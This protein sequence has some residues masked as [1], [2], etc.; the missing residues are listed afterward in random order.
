MGNVIKISSYRNSNSVNNDKSQTREER[1][2]GRPSVLDSSFAG[3]AEK[4]TQNLRF[5][6]DVRFANNHLAAILDARI[7]RRRLKRRVRDEIS[8]TVRN[9]FP[10]SMW[11]EAG[12]AIAGVLEDNPEFYS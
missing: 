6:T 9:R 5:S 2:S 7:G 4:V 1:S 10:K 12:D 8:M 11:L 3:A